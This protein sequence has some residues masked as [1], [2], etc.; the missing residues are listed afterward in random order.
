MNCYNIESQDKKIIVCQTTING[1]T[2]SGRLSGGN[3]IKTTSCCG[4]LKAVHHKRAIMFSK[5]IDST[6]KLDNLTYENDNNLSY[7]T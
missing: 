2:R 4:K 5:I 1:V 6:K 7:S 3:Y